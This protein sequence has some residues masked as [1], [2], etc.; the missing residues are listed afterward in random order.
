MVGH[1]FCTVSLKAN[2]SHAMQTPAVNVLAV[3]P[4]Y[5]GMAET[6]LET[7]VKNGCTDCKV[8]SLYSELELCLAEANRNWSKCQ[9]ELKSFKMCYDKCASVGHATR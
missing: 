9:N 8:Q 5:S 1:T 7:A 3:S 6:M 2:Q 4:A